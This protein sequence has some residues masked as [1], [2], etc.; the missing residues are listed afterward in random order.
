MSR[1][2]YTGEKAPLAEVTVSAS[3]D[4]FV[5]RPTDIIVQVKA[6]AAIPA[7]LKLVSLGMASKGTVL[8][9]EYAGT[10]YKVGSEVHDLAVGDFVTGFVHGSFDGTDANMGAFQ[11]YTVAPA[12]TAIK[13]N[14][15]VVDT[16][17]KDYVEEGPITTFEG[18]AS[19]GSSILTVG[20][21][22]HHYMKINGKEHAGKWILIWG[23]T[24]ATGFLAIQVAKKLYG[25][26]VIA[27]AN[28][29]KYGDR[30][31]AVGADVVVDYKD[32]DV[33]AQIKAATN[34]GVVFGF[35]TVSSDA[36][37][38]RK[39][40][41]AVSDS[42]P[43]HI[44]NFNAVTLEFGP[45]DEKKKQL[46]TFTT[47]VAFLLTGDDIP[48]WGVK[49]EESILTDNA[50]FKK[51]IAPLLSSGEIIHMPLHVHTGGLSG[52]N[53]ALL[54]VQKGVSF[55]REVIQVD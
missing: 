52:A 29:G 27:V 12:S 17:K 28:K 14:P 42:V 47:C 13:I 11:N 23:G 54:C 45:D 39:V 9:C 6:A 22:L 15:L 5:L 19:V 10:V 44:H 4:E 46:V 38:F 16:S 50:L 7:D 35:D 18:A 40:F 51:E 43:S 8:G 21:S 55:T 26:K 48:A 30:L 32:N 24:S 31:N 33:V 37:N 36:T 53:D 41:D 49:C 2:V 34:D 3:P 25:L 20:F 1:V